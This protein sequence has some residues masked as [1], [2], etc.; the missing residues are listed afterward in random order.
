VQGP[1]ITCDPVSSSTA[2]MLPLRGRPV[3]VSGIE[4]LE[5]HSALNHVSIGLHLQPILFDHR[6]AEDEFWR[7]FDAD[8]TRILGGL[9]DV[10]AEGLSL[11]HAERRPA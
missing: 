8:L 1:G 9:L 2:S 10:L 4:S 6:R 11:A 7:S 5:E 3:I